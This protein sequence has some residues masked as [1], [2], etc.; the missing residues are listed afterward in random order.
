MK[1]Q[2]P[3]LIITA[4]IGSSRLPGKVLKQFWNNLSL[5]EFLIK[6]LQTHTETARVVLA[7]VNNADNDPVANVGIKCGVKVT[8]GGED[9][10][11][12]RM[13]IAVTG[14]QAAFVGRVTADNPFTDPELIILQ[15]KKMK[16]LNADYSYCKES[17]IGT[18]IDLWTIACFEETVQKASTQYEHEHVNAYVWNHKDKF[19]NLWFT[20]PSDFLNPELN[21]SVDTL[22]EFVYI[23]SLAS[24][25][26]NPLTTNIGALISQSKTENIRNLNI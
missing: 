15:L 23:S 21:L 17:P 25:L 20:P 24:Q 26:A 18:A 14:E 22:E 6:R 19:D 8:R 4:R 16:L 5:L 10:V 13:N 2:R 11:L 7:T 9:D 3:L 12:G 1:D